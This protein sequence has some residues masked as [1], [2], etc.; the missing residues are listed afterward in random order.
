[1][2][3]KQDVYQNSDTLRQKA[4][5]TP[6]H[7]SQYERQVRVCQKQYERQVRVCQKHTS[8]YERQVRVCQKPK[9]GSDSLFKKRTVQKFDICSDDFPTETACNPQFKLKVTKITL[10]TLSVQIKI[11]LKHYTNL[12]R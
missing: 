10:L 3:Q 6:Q 9:I 2:D 7:T 5:H 4:K 12:T 8:Q 1:M 11:V